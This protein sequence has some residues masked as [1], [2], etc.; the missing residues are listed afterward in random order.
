[1][2]VPEL[3]EEDRGSH[4]VGQSW[5]ETEWFKRK[6]QEGGCWTVEDGSSEEEECHHEPDN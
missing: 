1:M 3:T 4:E 6:T 2:E 5:E